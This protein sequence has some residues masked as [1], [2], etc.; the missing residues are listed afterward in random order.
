MSC[1][2]AKPPTLAVCH[3]AFATEQEDDACLEHSTFLRRRHLHRMSRPFEKNASTPFHL[4]ARQSTGEKQQSPD[5]TNPGRTVS[6]LRLASGI[7]NPRGT[8]YSHI[9][10]LPRST[11]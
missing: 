8:I 6:S 1:F 9:P 2:G 4:R 7:L 3:G 10:R 5:Y 11:A